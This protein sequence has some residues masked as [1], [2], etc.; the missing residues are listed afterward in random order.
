MV[1]WF[2]GVNKVDKFVSSYL[3]FNLCFSPKIWGFLAPQVVAE[4]V[5][6]VLYV[7]LLCVCVLVV[8]SYSLLPSDYVPETCVC[9]LV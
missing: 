4:M 3:C 8:F 6:C 7:F 2:L 1:L 9:V 5:G